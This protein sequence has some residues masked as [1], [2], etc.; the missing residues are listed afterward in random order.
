M[1]EEHC[2]DHLRHSIMCS[3][4]FALDHWKYDAET[5]RRNRRAA[6]LQGLWCH[7]R[8]GGWTQMG[9][10]ASTGVLRNMGYSEQTAVA[11]LPS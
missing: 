5:N 7:E 3:G 11:C 1:G 2:I 8:M 9:V 6:C 10:G 4:N